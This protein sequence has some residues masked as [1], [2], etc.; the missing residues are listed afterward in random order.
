M[1]KES[2]CERREQEDE[3]IG[4]EDMTESLA[5]MNGN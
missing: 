2:R 1:N 5:F 4:L 3:K